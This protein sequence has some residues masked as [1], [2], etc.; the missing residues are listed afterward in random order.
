MSLSLKKSKVILEIQLS[1]HKIF[2]VRGCEL[3]TTLLKV[4]LVIKRPSLALQ[5]QI[6]KFDESWYKHE[7]L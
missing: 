7:T 4:D 2:N 3:V 6:A 5:P 1:L